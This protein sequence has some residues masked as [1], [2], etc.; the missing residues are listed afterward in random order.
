MNY[1]QFKFRNEEVAF[2]EFA[3]VKDGDIFFTEITENHILKEVSQ[4]TIVF[5]D[6]ID[7]TKGI[8]LVTKIIGEPYESDEVS[9][10]KAIP[11]KVIKKFDK[12]F[13][14]EKN[15]FKNLHDK[16]NTKKHIGRV[17]TRAEI[18]KKT[19]ERLLNKI[20]PNLQEPDLNLVEI[21]EGNLKNTL[22]LFLENY[23][24][25]QEDGKNGYYYNIFM[26]ANIAKQ[27][28]R[29]SSFLA[30]LLKIDG[31]HFHGNLFFKNFMN[32]LKQYAT[33]SQCEAITEFDIKNYS[34]QTTP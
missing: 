2:Q 18:D 31:N 27:E 32:E 19:A 16:L 4:D 9:S 11:M 5:W 21:D 17:R 30:N 13:V 20:I 3:T 26:E 15:G 8:M 33:L 12:P 23:K 10:G 7:K 24:Q 22:Q 14:L 6:R 29:H 28:I 34:V 25:Y 1:W